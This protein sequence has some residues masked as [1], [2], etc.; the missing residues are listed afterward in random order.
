MIVTDIFS[1]IKE[2]RSVRDFDP[3][4]SISRDELMEILELAGRAPSAWNL[5]HWHFMVFHGKE[6]QKKLL[7]IANNQIHV[8]ESS[9]VIAVLGDLQPDKKN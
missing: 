3:E 4:Q 6:I 9:A 7:P 1:I 5:Q 8:F 2:R